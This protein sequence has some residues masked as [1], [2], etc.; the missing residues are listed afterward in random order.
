MMLMPKAEACDKICKLL[1]LLTLL[2]DFEKSKKVKIMILM[3]LFVW[4]L[5]IW[6]GNTTSGIL[7]PKVENTDYL[8]L[9]RILN[10]L[11]INQLQ[12]LVNAAEK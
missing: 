11:F 8:R 7:L 5:I 4:I 3:I 12:Q 10:L 1:W 9:L 2:G 6:F